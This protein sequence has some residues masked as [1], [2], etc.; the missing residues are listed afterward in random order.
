MRQSVV[1]LERE[2][3]RNDVALEA[4]T[5]WLGQVLGQSSVA[6]REPNN[7]VAREQ[8]RNNAAEELELNGRLEQAC[9]SCNHCPR[10]DAKHRQLPWRWHKRQTQRISV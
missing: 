6:E 10:K 4:S 3:V 7:A 5:R 2:L 9:H 1:A 8:E